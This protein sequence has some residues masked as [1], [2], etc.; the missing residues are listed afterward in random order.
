MLHTIVGSDI[1]QYFI[2]ILYTFRIIL[3]KIR[4]CACTTNLSQYLNSID[5]R[6]IHNSSLVSKCISTEYAYINWKRKEISYLFSFVNFVLHLDSRYW[7]SLWTTAHTFHKTSPFFEN[8]E[9]IKYIIIKLIGVSVT[10]VAPEK[11]HFVINK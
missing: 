6:A 3:W 7:N 2:I 8:D 11:F 1:I 10:S 4:W 9:H 5:Q